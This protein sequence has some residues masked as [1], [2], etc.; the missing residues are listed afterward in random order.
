MT[1]APNDFNSQIIDEFRSKDGEVGGPFEGAPLLLL[2]TTGAHSGAERV[3]PVMY[4]RIDDGR[5]AVFASKGGAPTNP[6]WFHNLMAHPDATVELGAET[7]A[8]RARVAD[9][10]AEREPIWTAQKKEYPGFAGYEAN[11]T[12]RIPVVVLERVAAAS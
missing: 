3:N 8:V 4:R 5:V 11:T 1:T 6:D 2:H 9:D 10:D 7:F 12:R